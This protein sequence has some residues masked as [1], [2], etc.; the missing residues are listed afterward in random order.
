VACQMTPARLEQT[1]LNLGESSGKHVFRATGSVVIFPGFLGVYQEG[2]DDTPGDD[3]EKILPAVSEGA[4]LTI[5][6]VTTDQHFTEPPPRFTEATLVKTLEEYGIGRP[7]TYATII[8]TLQD[9]GYVKLDKKRFFPEDVGRVVSRFLTQHFTQYVDYNFTAQLEEDLDAIARGEHDWKPTLR[10]FWAPFRDLVKEKQDTVK[11][12]DVTHEATGEPCPK[13]KEGELI[14][15]LGRFGKFKGCNRFPECDYI[16]KKETAPGDA[17]HVQGTGITC[18]LCSK[19]EIAERTG[20]FGKF[21]SCTNYPECKFAV[22]D[23][24]TTTPCPKC[25]FP[26]TTMKTTKRYGEVHKCSN[27]GWWSNDD[28]KAASEAFKA[29]L[30]ERKGAKGK[31]GKAGAD[32]G[33]AAPAKKAPAKKAAPKKTAAQKLGVSKVVKKKAPPKKPK[34]G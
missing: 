18:P 2:K 14:Y 13:C 23:A 24:P 5:N 27:C 32:E 21:Y 29:R 9:R 30:A 31:K 8:S 10:Q 6:D 33:E 20:R 28:A 19:G 25:Y 1:T 15:R 22:P 16:E 34:Q 11:K 7:S 17:G 26:V 12:S 4:A 3:D